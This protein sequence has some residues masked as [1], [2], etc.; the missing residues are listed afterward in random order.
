MPDRLLTEE[1]YKALLPW[2][3]HAKGEAFL[4]IGEDRV[5]IPRL[6]F[7]HIFQRYAEVLAG[8]AAQ[9]KPG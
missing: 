1:E 7:I 9:D 8:M 2:R 3:D 4:E 6:T 5:F